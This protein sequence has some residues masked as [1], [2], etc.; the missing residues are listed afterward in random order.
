MNE[1][2]L[3]HKDAIKYTA[4]IGIPF[5]WIDA[6]CILQDDKKDW[7]REIAAMSKIYTQSFLTIAAGAS[8]HC[9]GGFLKAN[10]EK[11]E[12]P[13]PRKGAFGVKADFSPRT[14][15]PNYWIRPFLQ[16]PLFSR[17]WALQERELAPRIMHFTK[18]FTVWEC[19]EECYMYVRPLNAWTAP[20]ILFLEQT[21]YFLWRQWPFRCF[22]VDPRDRRKKRDVAHLKV[23]TPFDVWQWTVEKFSKRSLTFP[24]DKLA[25][26]GGLANELQKHVKCDYLAGL[27]RDDLLRNLLW[28]RDGHDPV[29]DAQV[30]S[31]SQAP[32]W[33]WG[34]T[35]FPITF[36]NDADADE[37]EVLETKTISEGYPSIPSPPRILIRLRAKVLEVPG[38][39]G[40]F[41]LDDPLRKPSPSEDF[42][43]C[44]VRSSKTL[45]EKRGEE[46][47]SEVAQKYREGGGLGL[48]LEAVEGGEAF[49]RLGMIELVP[50][51]MIEEAKLTEISIV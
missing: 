7:G 12:L 30:L 8:D 19:R 18:T 49:R 41:Y 33:S 46:D 51:V 36:D 4:S 50:E 32:S 25:A 29:H 20:D 3:T 24:G 16:N 43:V 47:G 1:L 23:V 38:D 45:E 15:E 26:M 37:A 17:G 14:E 28:H 10:Y 44:I 34:N 39:Y 13:V 22:D 21:H 11:S 2:P 42:T 40:T 6:L 9:D 5:L 48:V 31:T 35:N 27:W